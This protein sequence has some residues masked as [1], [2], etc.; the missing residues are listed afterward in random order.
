MRGSNAPLRTRVLDALIVAGSWVPRS[1]LAQL[2]TSQMAVDDVLADLVVQGVATFRE[3]VGYRLAGTPAAR[4]AAQMLRRTGKKAAAVGLPG[5][6]FYQVGVAE[7]RPAPVGLVLYELAIPNPEP[8]PQ[9]LA[10][11]LQQV[12]G[13]LAFINS[14]GGPDGAGV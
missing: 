14:R 1:E 6:E 9:A 7:V 2:S 3:N 10:Q 13:V 11:H 12:G 8:G 4:R 5:K